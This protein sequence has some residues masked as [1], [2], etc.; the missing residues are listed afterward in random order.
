M[1]L[2]VSL[3]NKKA[4]VEKERGEKMLYPGI[5][6]LEVNTEDGS[7]RP[8]KVRWWTWKPRG[9]TG[10]VS[11][12]DGFL[13]LLQAKIHKLFWFDKNYKVRKRWILKKVKDGHS[14]V[15]KNGKVYIASTGNDSIV[16]FDPETE[17]ER[18]FWKENSFG[19]DTIHLNSMIW[20]DDHMI[21]SAFG[22]KAGDQWMSAR[23]G[24]LMDIKTGKKI[25]DSLF[26]P[27]TLLKNRE[28]IFFCESA[29]KKVLSMDGSD[30]LDIGKGYV[31]GL[32]ITEEEIA[33]GISHARRRSKSTG[34]LNRMDNELMHS[35]RSGCGIKVYKRCGKKLKKSRLIRF[36]NLYPFSSE[37]YDLIS[38]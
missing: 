29:R 32:L 18:V 36:V 20:D 27:H 11:Y 3:C 33:V 16:E 14:L 17:E 35:F 38:I 4:S 9:V 6:L 31:R 5:F 19:K 23:N 13:C 24:Y 2:I 30:S 12:K 25:R 21:I 26:H 37:I 10:L 7:I 34:R 15:T 22:K 28:G 8:I 1:K